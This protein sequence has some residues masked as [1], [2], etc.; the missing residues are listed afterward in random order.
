M[1]FLSGDANPFVSTD[2]Q[3]ES[4]G[5]RVG[6]S[7]DLFEIFVQANPLTHGEVILLP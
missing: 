1:N 2:V 4:P 6:K 3:R 5:D 7:D